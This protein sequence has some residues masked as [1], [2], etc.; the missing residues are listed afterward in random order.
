MNIDEFRKNAHETVDWIADY[1]QNIEKYP[2]KS[3][4]NPGDIFKQLPE[5]AQEGPEPY[6]KIIKDLDEIIMPGIT[7]WQSP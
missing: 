4:V 7:H 2:V 1:F 3:Q 6:S 5:K